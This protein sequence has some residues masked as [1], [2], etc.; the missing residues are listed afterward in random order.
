MSVA[1][2]ASDQHGCVPIVPGLAHVGGQVLNVESDAAIVTAIGHRRVQRPPVMKRSLPGLQ[3][4]HDGFRFGYVAH[5][6]SAVQYVARVVCQRVLAPALEVT[7]RHHS[8]AAALCGRG[9]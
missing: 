3:R 1:V 7:A 9:R 2:F 6:L 8:H 5:C 4:A